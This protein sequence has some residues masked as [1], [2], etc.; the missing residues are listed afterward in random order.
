[1]SMLEL[2]H[3]A[4]EP[5]NLPFTLLLIIVLLYWLTVI[6]GLLD[7]NVFDLHVDTHIHPHVHVD[8]GVQ[9]DVDANAGF[10]STILA[11]F[12]VGKVPFMVIISVLALFLWVGSMLGNYYIGQ[13]SSLVAFL[14]LVPNMA[15]GLFMTKFLTNPL[16]HLFRDTPNEFERNRDMVGRTCTIL[17]P[18]SDQKIGQ[19]EVGVQRGAPVLVIVKATDG[20]RLTRGEKGLIID[21]DKN[22]HTYLIEPYQ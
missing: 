14:L 1:M 4:F 6:V 17:L 20:H 9:I 10:F 3:F 11:F 13:G 12:N 18:V 22:S 5:V 16:Q 2:L 21:Y 8:K 19:A 15:V 7:V